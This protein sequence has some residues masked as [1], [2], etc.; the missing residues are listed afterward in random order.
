M[1]TPNPIPYADLQES[2]ESHDNTQ[3]IRLEF[4]KFFLWIVSITEIVLSSVSFVIQVLY[5]VLYVRKPAYY[6]PSTLMDAFYS[7]GLWC[8]VA[9]FLSGMLGVLSINQPIYRKRNLIL[10]MLSIA[11]MAVVV[12]WNLA[13]GFGLNYYEL[14]ILYDLTTINSL[15]LLPF[16]IM[17]VILSW[18]L[19]YHRDKVQ[20]LQVTFNRTQEGQMTAATLQVQ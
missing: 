19:Y 14:S 7:R 13:L 17:H 18:R 16:T 10:S 4:Q 6:R 12:I 2:S 15:I 3:K 11:A 9:P 8:M 20:E 1:V 5:L